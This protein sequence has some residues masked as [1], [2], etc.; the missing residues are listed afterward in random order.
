M[1]VTVKGFLPDLTSY[2]IFVD[3]YETIIERRGIYHT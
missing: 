3:F 2:E 1:P